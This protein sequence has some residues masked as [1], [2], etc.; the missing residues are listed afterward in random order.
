MLFTH[1]KT[2]KIYRLLAH[3]IDCTNSRDGTGI[4]IYCTDD[5]EH[6]IFVRETKEFHDKFTIVTPN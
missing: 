5:N 3:G 6:T 2:G 1:D 4:V